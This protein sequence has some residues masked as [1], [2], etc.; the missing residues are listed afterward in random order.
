MECGPSTQQP[1]TRE[2]RQQFSFENMR[3]EGRKQ[4]N[5]ELIQSAE[6]GRKERMV[7]KHEM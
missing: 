5:K 3:Q 2:E 4:D 7:S 6:R 1:T